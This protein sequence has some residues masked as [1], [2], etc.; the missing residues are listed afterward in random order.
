VEATIKV[1]KPKLKLMM[2]GLI[3]LMT[4]LFL[5]TLFLTT[6]FLTTQFLT[7]MLT[8]L[9]NFRLPQ[10]LMS[11]VEQYR[12]TIFVRHTVVLMYLPNIAGQTH[13]PTLLF[14]RLS[15]MMKRPLVELE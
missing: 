8:T 7:T 9:L 15:W 14:M 2:M 1:K 11:R 13:L 5:T 3:Q 10:K 6:Q 4:T 12:W